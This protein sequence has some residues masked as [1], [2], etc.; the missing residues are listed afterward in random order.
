MMFFKR[1]NSNNA[2]RMFILKHLEKLKQNSN[3]YKVINNN[4]VLY[5]KNDLS[6]L[7]KSYVESK[8][9]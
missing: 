3:G 1:N 7:N 9:S 6:K 8:V 5:T 4:N 2:K